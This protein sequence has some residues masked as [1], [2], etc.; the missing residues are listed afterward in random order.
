MSNAESVDE[1]KYTK[2]KNELILLS[3]IV[4]LYPIVVVIFNNLFFNERI[5]GNLPLIIISTII[6]I[7][8]A[9]GVFIKVKWARYI[10][11]AYYIVVLY[12]FIESA[13]KLSPYFELLLDKFIPPVYLVVIGLIIYIYFIYYLLFNRNLRYFLANKPPMGK[14]ETI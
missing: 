6:Q 11:V 9:R 7:G 5:I 4:I 13:L 14:R 8:L 10:S 2:G 3:I 1:C 12:Y